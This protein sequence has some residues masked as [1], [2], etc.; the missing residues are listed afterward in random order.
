MTASGSHLDS[1]NFACIYTQLRL[2]AS[3]VRAG[4]FPMAS[5]A[6]MGS[7]EVDAVDSCLPESHVSSCFHNGT[8][9]DTEHSVQT[10]DHIVHAFDL[11]HSDD[12]ITV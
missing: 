4:I 2:V 6:F 11:F 12:I 5:T 9:D 7:I 1:R 8:I 3:G 10:L